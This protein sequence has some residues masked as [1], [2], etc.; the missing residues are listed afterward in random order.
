MK[1]V[2]ESNLKWEMQKVS[3][4]EKEVKKELNGKSMP[5]M[6]EC[7]ENTF[8]PEETMKA[9]VLRR[10]ELGVVEEEKEDQ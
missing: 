7:I 9:N 6:G 4:K 5:V 8:Q 10:R 2:S 3:P 1:V